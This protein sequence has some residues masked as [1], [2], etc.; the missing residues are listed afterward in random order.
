MHQ[1]SD[2]QYA[3]DMTNHS[4]LKTKTKSNNKNEMLKHTTVNKMLKICLC[5][6]DFTFESISPLLSR[7]KLTFLSLI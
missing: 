7:D 5:D 6:F 2:R 1:S 4:I 3:F